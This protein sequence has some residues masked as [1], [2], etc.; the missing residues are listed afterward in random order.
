MHLSVAGSIDGDDDDD[1]GDNDDGNDDDDGDYDN[2]FI[3]AVLA[4]EY[5]S[6]DVNRCWWILKLIRFQLIEF[7]TFDFHGRHPSVTAC[8][9]CRA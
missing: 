9:R 4:I 7:P 2:T 8:Y 6:L 3:H 5:F 1:D